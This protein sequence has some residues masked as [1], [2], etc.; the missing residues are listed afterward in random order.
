MANPQTLPEVS[1][2][3]SS[4]E[5]E[6]R[7]FQAGEPWPGDAWSYVKG[8]PRVEAANKSVDTSASEKARA[9]NLSDQLA[10]AMSDLATVSQERDIAAG[11]LHDAEQAKIIAE[12]AMAQ[13][14]DRAK[15]YMEERDAA[16]R[17]NTALTT[18]VTE[19]TAKV[20][21]LQAEA[22]KIPGL[23]EN[24]NEANQTI[25]NQNA[26]IAM[27]EGTIQSQ[28]EMID[29][30]EKQLAAKPAKKGS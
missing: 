2:L 22:D 10:S 25:A 18:K 21:E 11:A 14:E 16:L 20:E 26:T 28:S 19:L 12:N 13:A 1:T 4:T 30:L 29:E 23:M 27:Q 7:V 15:E 17:D 24:A 8:G 9:D 3:Y 5:P 6:G